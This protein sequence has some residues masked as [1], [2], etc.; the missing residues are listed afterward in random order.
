MNSLRF[1][2]IGKNPKVRK[3][4]EFY[5]KCIINRTYDT[6]SDIARK[7]G[8]SEGTIYINIKKLYKSN[9]LGK[10]LSNAMVCEYKKHG[11][12][13]DRWQENYKPCNPKIIK[14]PKIPHI[15]ELPF[16][17]EVKT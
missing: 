7:Y 6:K 10:Y 3:T 16:S 17:E 9:L 8:I 12:C 1:F 14:M 5:L 15:D 11:L 13:R 4:V 2:W